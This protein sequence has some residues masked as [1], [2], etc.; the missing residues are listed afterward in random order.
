VSVDTDLTFT[1][2]FIFVCKMLFLNENPIFENLLKLFAYEQHLNL[3]P[4]THETTDEQHLNLYPLTHETTDE[5][6]LKCYQIYISYNY[7]RFIRFLGEYVTLNI[8]QPLKIISMK[9][10]FH[11][12]IL[13]Y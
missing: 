5:Q 10:N 2:I 11:L 9:L 13:H 3:Y 4:L 1:I 7:L 12:F 8:C 6:H